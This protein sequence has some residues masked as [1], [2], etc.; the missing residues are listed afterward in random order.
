MTARSKFLS[1]SASRT[2]L[3]LVLG[4]LALA[5]TLIEVGPR[6]GRTFDGLV[7]VDIVDHPQYE[8]YP[9]VK[10]CPAKGTVYWLVPN[11]DLNGQMTFYPGHYIQGTWRVKFRGDL[12]GV[13]RY[14]YSS[15]YWRELRVVDVYE[16][17]ELNCG[18]FK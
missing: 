9:D 17:T 11:E 3:L 5:G 4:V 12:S 7:V 18:N 15:R 1:S 6:P 10:E 2:V 13:G 8:F 14:G 16:V